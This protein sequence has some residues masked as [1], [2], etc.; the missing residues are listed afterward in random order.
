L[1][2][3]SHVGLHPRLGKQVRVRT[4]AGRMVSTGRI[5]AGVLCLVGGE[6]GSEFIFT[7]RMAG[8]RRS[9]MTASLR[10]TFG[11]AGTR[12]VA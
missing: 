7:N 5:D 8:G 1:K 9:H 11:T 6:L 12:S 3:L 2:G 10:K 4:A